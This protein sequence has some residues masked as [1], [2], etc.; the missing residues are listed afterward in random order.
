MGFSLC[1]SQASHT[2]S[3]LEGLA[4]SKA[5]LDIVP[6]FDI[7][8]FVG[9]PAE[10]DHAAIPHRGKI[11]QS[12][13]VVLQLNPQGLQIARAHRQIH[14]EFSV[15]F[16]VRNAS[17]AVFGSLGSVLGRLLKSPQAPV[18]TLDLLHDRPHVFEQGIC[19]FNCKQL[20]TSG[21]ILLSGGG[22]R[23]FRC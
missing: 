18:G 11:N 12:V 7:V 15:A 9:L 8:A 22:G 2:E 3:M 10:Q 21:T 23:Y 13:V 14:K 4:T 1:L 5:G 17:A 19:F 16:A 20:H 6:P